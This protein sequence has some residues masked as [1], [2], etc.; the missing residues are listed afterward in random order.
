[1]PEPV[2]AS[3]LELYRQG[4]S[5]VD[6]AIEIVQADIDRR[7]ANTATSQELQ[8]AK[9]L[10][11]VQ[12]AAQD[13]ARQILL[14]GLQ[15]RAAEIQ[16]QMD[17]RLLA[18]QDEL[19]RRIASFQTQ[20]DQRVVGLQDATSDLKA[21]L[22]E[23]FATQTKALDTAM[24]AQQTAMSTA[25]TAADAAVKAAL[26]AA[27]TAV[28]KAEVA[29]EKR[30]ES[31]N[32]FRKTLTDQTAQFMTRDEVSVRIEALQAIQARSSEALASL[33]LRLSSRL[34][35]GKGA[36]TGR[37]AFDAG[38]EAKM[39]QRLVV[40]AVVISVIVIIVNITIAL[41]THHA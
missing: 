5:Y 22:D 32:E 39:N 13:D 15:G 19:D 20:L 37:T 34:D 40:M 17:R 4:R 10:I 12:Q 35:L 26:T 16:A 18:L 7:L 11:K 9:E 1:M 29:T 3:D 25:M 31:V 41:V 14:A 8:S 6:H 28:N 33:E 21:R 27:E 23:R 30:F 38:A 24:T 36:E 2:A